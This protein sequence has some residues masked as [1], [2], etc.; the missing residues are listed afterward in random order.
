MHIY[1]AQCMET[2]L[3]FSKIQIPQYCWLYACVV[4][5]RR[6]G[7]NFVKFIRQHRHIVAP[8]SHI[9]ILRYDR[10]QYDV[11][12]CLNIKAYVYVSAARVCV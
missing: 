4:T 12:G 6:G 1:G 5:L 10:S 9:T 7:A 2:A 3:F 11:I 8:R